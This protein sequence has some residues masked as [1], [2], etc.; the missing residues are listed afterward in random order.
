MPWRVSVLQQY[1]SPACAALSERE[2]NACMQ[3]PSKQFPRRLCMRIA[4][5]SWEDNLQ[6]LLEV[7]EAQQAAAYDS[8]V[9]KIALATCG[10]GDMVAMVLTETPAP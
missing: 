10:G 9:L 2:R 7:A 1:G 8:A 6:Y 4:D 3:T 5:V